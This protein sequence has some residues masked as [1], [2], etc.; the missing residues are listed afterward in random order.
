M[1]SNRNSHILKI[2]FEDVS[3]KSSI[4]NSGSLFFAVCCCSQFFGTF[5]LSNVKQ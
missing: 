5:K 3:E 1:L 4:E 2:K